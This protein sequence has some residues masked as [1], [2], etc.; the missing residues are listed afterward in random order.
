MSAMVRPKKVPD[1]DRDQLFHDSGIADPRQKP[2]PWSRI[3]YG[4][5]Q[6][7]LQIL[8]RHNKPEAPAPLRYSVRFLHQRLPSVRDEHLA[9]EGAFGPERDDWSFERRP[10]VATL[11]FAPTAA[12]NTKKNRATTNLLTRVEADDFVWLPTA[13]SGRQGLPAR[14]CG[15]TLC[16]WCQGSVLDSRAES[17]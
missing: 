11:G 9:A 8:G 10:A 5:A 14:A 13:I 3:D 12:T 2:A 7:V 17:F 4:K 16:R 15:F 6:F 1:R